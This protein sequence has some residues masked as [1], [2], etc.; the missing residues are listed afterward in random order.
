MGRI[1]IESTCETEVINAE[2]FF[3]ASRSLS[4]EIARKTAENLVI[5]G[6]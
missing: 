1:I 4:R 5:P 6:K 3:Y 2:Y